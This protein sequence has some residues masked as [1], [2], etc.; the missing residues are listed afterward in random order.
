M[1]GG[2]DRI[3]NDPDG[4]VSSDQYAQ[5]LNVSSSVGTECTQ[6]RVFRVAS[7]I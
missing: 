1:R 6:L 5:M 4:T 2:D 3:M 7:D